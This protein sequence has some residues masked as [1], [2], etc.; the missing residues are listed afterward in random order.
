M[1]KISITKFLA[2]FFASIPDCRPCDSP[3]TVHP[4]CMPIEVPA[5]DPYYPQVNFTTG[6]RFCLPFMRSLPGQQRLG[7]TPSLQYFKVCI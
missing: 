6:Q 5:G 3:Q 2:G 7:K 1:P 4:E